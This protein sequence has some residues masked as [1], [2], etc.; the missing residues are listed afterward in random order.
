MAW[1]AYIP[2]T[3]WDSNNCIHQRDQKCQ[4]QL[5]TANFSL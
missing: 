4:K 3:N 2:N 5:S 1:T